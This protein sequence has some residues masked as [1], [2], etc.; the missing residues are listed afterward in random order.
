M[1]WKSPKDLVRLCCGSLWVCVLGFVS[2]RSPAGRDIRHPDQA[3]GERPAGRSPSPA[4]HR[5]PLSHCR[6]ELRLSWGAFCTEISQMSRGITVLIKHLENLAGSP[7]HYPWCSRMLSGVLPL[8]SLLS[9]LLS[10]SMSPFAQPGE[11][12]TLGPEG[13]TALP[14]LGGPGVSF[15]HQT[16]YG[17]HKVVGR[18]RWS[19]KSGLRNIALLVEPCCI[20]WSCICEHPRGE[21][22]V[23]GQMQCFQCFFPGCGAQHV[24]LGE[25][26]LGFP[27]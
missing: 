13:E 22:Y 10:S 27:F 3:G 5:L 2:H 6:A 7:L 8:L 18:T 1:G 20:A 26:S 17:H 4:V 16:C 21:L 12:L 19:R 24:Q 23:S 9:E 14:N 11:T 15:H 25:I